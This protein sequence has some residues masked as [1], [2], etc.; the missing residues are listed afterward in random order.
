M[1][2]RVINTLINT[3]TSISRKGLDNVSEDDVS[4]VSATK[5]KVPTIN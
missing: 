2:K 3:T 1:M 5:T 4:L